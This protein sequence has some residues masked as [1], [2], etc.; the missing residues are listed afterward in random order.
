[1]AS[2]LNRRTPSI[3]L[4]VAA[5]FWQAIEYSLFRLPL[6]VKPPVP[7]DGLHLSAEAGDETQFN[8]RAA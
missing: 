8:V 2:G 5:T 7:A 4:I 3:G 1:M 6:G